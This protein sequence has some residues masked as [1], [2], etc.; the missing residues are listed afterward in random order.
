[1]A[2]YYFDLEDGQSGRDEEGTALPTLKSMR[3]AAVEM[4][5][6]VLRD[7]SDTFWDGPDLMLTVRDEKDLVLVRLTVFGTLSAASQ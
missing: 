4:L 5:G 3:V 6:Q 7:R 1:M 2:R